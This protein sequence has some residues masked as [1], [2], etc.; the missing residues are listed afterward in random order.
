[1][2]IKE[3]FEKRKK[4]GQKALITYIVSGDFGYEKYHEYGKC[5]CGYRRDR[6]SVF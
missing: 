1:M 4:N 3:A 2:R 5:R 6:N